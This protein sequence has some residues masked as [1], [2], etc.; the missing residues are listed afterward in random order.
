MPGAFKLDYSRGIQS[1][2]MGMLKYYG[3]SGFPRD[4]T[5][6][7]PLLLM[8]WILLIGETLLTSVKFQEESDN[9][10]DI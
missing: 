4:V 8:P 7:Y 9:Q 10:S 5:S 2:F 6:S 1:N 3:S